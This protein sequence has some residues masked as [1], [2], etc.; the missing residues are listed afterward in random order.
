MTTCWAGIRLQQDVGRVDGGY[1][2][3]V[4]VNTLYRTLIVIIIVT[5]LSIQSTSQSVDAQPSFF[6]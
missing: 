2:L 3:D 4:I 6:L 5:H 1:L